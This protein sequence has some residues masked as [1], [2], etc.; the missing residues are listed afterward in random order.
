[1]NKDRILEIVK[2]E[3]DVLQN[4]MMIDA[5]VSIK[6]EDGENGLLV[7]KVVFEG[8]DL[9][10]MIGNRGL[11]LQGF[12]YVLSNIVKSKVRKETGEEEIKLAILVDVGGYRE[13]RV[14]KIERLAMQKADDARI[15][16]DAV[17]LLPMSSSDR[18]IVHAVLGKFD[19]IK[20]ESFGD[21]RERFVRITPLKD[22]E[23][24]VSSKVDE[25]S[26]EEE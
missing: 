3:V 14:E 1:M 17:D 7:A 26:S 13:Q 15:L 8:E 18:R 9:G 19:D 4:M 24:G 5:T 23:I 20:T 6:V 16:G 10:Y 22:E 12:Q 11:H 21:D 2:N 25:K